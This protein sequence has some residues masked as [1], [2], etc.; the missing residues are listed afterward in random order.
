[1]FK[2]SK[3]KNVLSILKYNCIM[4]GLMKKFTQKGCYHINKCQVI[5]CNKKVYMI[6]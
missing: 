3:M 1:M 4:N 2:Y 5:G 6:A